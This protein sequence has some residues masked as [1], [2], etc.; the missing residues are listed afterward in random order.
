MGSSYIFQINMTYIIYI[1]CC[2]R[3]LS[4]NEI[5][6][7][8]ADS[9]SSLP[10]LRILQLDNNKINC[11]DKQAFTGKNSQFSETFYG[12]HKSLKILLVVDMKNT[13]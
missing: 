2:F 11:I 10:Y 13:V 7:L 4:Y 3:D 12:V 8:P 1:F 6:S 5:T 9:V